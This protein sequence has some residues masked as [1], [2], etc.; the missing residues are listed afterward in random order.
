MLHHIK[1]FLLVRSQD[2]SPL[3]TNYTLIT[4]LTLS[5]SLLLTPVAIAGFAP[6]TRIPASDYTRSAGRRGCPGNAIPLTVLA[7]QTYIAYTASLR[8]TFVGFVSSPQK[9]NFRIFELMPDNK[10]QQLGEAIQK[11]VTPGIFQISL[12]ESTS[13]LTVGK[14]YVWQLAIKCRGNPVHQEA[15]FVVVE[16]P[17]TVESKLPTTPDGWQKAN[18]YAQ[19]DLWYEAL[20]EAL[21]SAN[22][23]KLGEFGSTLVK[24][25]AAY[26]SIVPKEQ[27]TSVQKR[28]QHLKT[29]AIQEKD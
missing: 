6:R 18:I 26:E 24:N 1:L 28:V 13:D 3:F 2:F 27:Q 20:A 15:E 29:I 9:V 7:P 22:N 19:A 14:K 16:M 23:G 8:P 21:K 5:L 10:P 12:P 4:T 11:N 17:S 25:L